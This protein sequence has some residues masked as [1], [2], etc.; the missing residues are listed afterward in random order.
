MPYRCDSEAQ[1]LRCEALEGELSDLRLRVSALAEARR[2]LALKEREAVAARRLLSGG[3][4]DPSPPSRRRAIAVTV[5]VSGLVAA[6][7]LVA[8]IPTTR[9]PQIQTTLVCARELRRAAEVWRATHEADLCP[10]T[11]GLVADGE[12]DP[13]SKLTDSWGNPYLIL[14][15]EDE[16]I[17]IS[18]GRDAKQGTADDIRVPPVAR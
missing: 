15:E 8:W 7:A 10:T 1:R 4:D 12:I 2:Q 16:T 9:R 5:A 17:V 6:G 13:A 18:V 14:C 3:T 11:D